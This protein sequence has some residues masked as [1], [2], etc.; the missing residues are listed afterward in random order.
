MA[1]RS[2]PRGCCRA[3][4]VY[5]VRLAVLLGLR[6]E[7]GDRRTGVRDGGTLFGMT[8]ASAAP[9]SAPPAVDRPAHYRLGDAT[10]ALILKEYREGAT[11]PFLASKWRVSA[12]AVRKRIT[13]HGSSKRDWGDAQAVAQVAAARRRSRRRGGPVPRGWRGGCSTVWCWARPR[14]RTRRR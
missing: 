3:G 10:W 14:R 12:H 6:T 7:G 4:R 8:S 1:A 9:A 2:W 5:T 11:A 13:Q